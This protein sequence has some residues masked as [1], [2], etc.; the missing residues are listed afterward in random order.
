MKD[1]RLLLL[2]FLTT[3]SVFSQIKGIVVDENNSPIPY[4][5]IWVEGE[6]I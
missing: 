4:V 6:N 1:K 5:N 3:S 2:F